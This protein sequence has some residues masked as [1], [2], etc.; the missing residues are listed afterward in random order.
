M[1]MLL[2]GAMLIGLATITGEWARLS[3]TTRTAS[4]MIYLVVIGS[5]IGYSAYV[6]AL[7]YLPISTVSLYAYVNPIIAVVLGTVLLAEPFSLRIVA[8]A[9]LVFGG[10]AV[11]RRGSTESRHGST[12]TRRHPTARRGST[13]A[14]KTR[15]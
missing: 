7:K 10:I 14:R 15:P 8:A 13:E 1:Q 4:A 9:A 3:F 2:S 12:E 11:V 5:V 6:Y